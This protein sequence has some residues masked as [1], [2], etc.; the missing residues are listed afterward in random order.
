MKNEG[1]YI[2]IIVSLFVIVIALVGYIIYSNKDR[3]NV[4]NNCVQCNNKTI[5]EKENEE[6]DK[7]EKTVTIELKDNKKINIEETYNE[8]ELVTYDIKVNNYTLKIYYKNGY[9]YFETTND[10]DSFYTG[11]NNILYSLQKYNNYE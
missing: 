7:K 8:E 5:N 11:D 1:V 4:V 3:N 9:T 6:T 10:I 2:G